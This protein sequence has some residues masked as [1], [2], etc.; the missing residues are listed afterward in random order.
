[1]ATISKPFSSVSLQEAVDLIA[2]I[3][4]SVTVVMQGHIGTG[5]SSMINPIE[6][7]RAHV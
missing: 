2:A 6:I 1:M 4:S 7:G 5:K 3:G